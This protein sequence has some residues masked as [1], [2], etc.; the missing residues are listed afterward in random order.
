MSRE[1]LFA[2]C[3]LIYLGTS[4]VS[5]PDRPDAPICLHNSDGWVCTDS[6]GD[7]KEQENNLVC[8]SI[9]GYSSLEKYIDVLELKIRQF[10]RTC[11]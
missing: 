5:K 3:C 8:T 4:C 7:F 10:E 6:R 9:A 1:T 2:A 11:R